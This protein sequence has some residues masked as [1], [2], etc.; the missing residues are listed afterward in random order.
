MLTFLH[1]TTEDDDLAELI[2]KLDED[3]RFREGTLQDVYNA[4]NKLDGI[5]TAVVARED[6]APVGCG[7][8][9]QYDGETVEV[10]R[11]FVDPAYR[12]RGIAG[13]ILRGLEAWAQE[14][15]SDRAVLETGL[16]Q[17]EA[18][19]LYEKSGYRRISNYGPYKSMPNSV[20]FEKMLCGR[21]AELETK[22]EKE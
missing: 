19:H 18:I 1:C 6:G 12:N 7:C 15:G 3:L 2:R 22:G 13:K 17:P 4:Y 21:T 9:K 10:K 11:I 14:R 8:L 5:L 16:R 20:C